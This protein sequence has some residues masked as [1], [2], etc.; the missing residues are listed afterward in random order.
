M[1][2]STE[3]FT[4]VEPQAG[5]FAAQVSNFVVSLIERIG[6][7]K[8]RLHQDD[9]CSKLVYFKEQKIYFALKKLGNNDFCHSGNTALHYGKNC[10]KASISALLKTLAQSDLCHT[11]NI[12]LVGLPKSKTYFTQK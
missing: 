7:F 2:I 1:E 4:S 12:A 6:S 8:A 11:V 9:N 10:F 5:Y 3:N